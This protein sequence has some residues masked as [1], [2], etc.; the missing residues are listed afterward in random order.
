MLFID[1]GHGRYRKILYAST[2]P[3]LPFL[4]VLLTDLTFIEDGQSTFV[5][6]LA[7]GTPVVNFTKQTLVFN[8]LQDFYHYVDM[9]YT[10]RM[11]PPVLQLLETLPELADREL[12]ELSLVR[13]PK[14]MSRSD[15][16]LM[17]MGI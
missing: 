5:A 13:E 2:P 4:G 11:A 16:D 14:G 1:Q 3:A 15:V 17:D 9:K 12:S 8:V 10:F 6:P 7:D